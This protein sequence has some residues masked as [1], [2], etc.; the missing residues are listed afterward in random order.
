MGGGLGLPCLVNKQI[1]LDPVRGILGFL[2]QALC[3][4]LEALTEPDADWPAKDC[5]EWLQTAANIFDLV[6][7]GEG[8]VSVSLARGSLAP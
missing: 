5:L 2:M 4:F 6:Y 7:K 8:G 1:S 3:V